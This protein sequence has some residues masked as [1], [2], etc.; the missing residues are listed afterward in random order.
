[1]EDKVVRL[2]GLKGVR[3][4]FNMYLGGKD[5]DALFTA[6]RELLDN[7]SDLALK[8]NLKVKV[9]LAID[10]GNY[11]VVDDGPGMPV[12]KDI[13]EDER[14]RKEKL[15]SLYV[16]TGLT[17]AGT[18]FNSDKTSKGTHGIGSKSTNAISHVYEVWTFKDGSWWYIQY[19]NAVLT[20]EP[21][22][23]KAPPVVPFIGKVKKGTIVHCKPDLSLFAKDTKFP[24]SR[25]K[26]WCELSSYLIPNQTSAVYTSK[27]SKVYEPQGPEVYIKK[28]CERLDVEVIGKAL[29]CHDA[30]F[31]LAVAWSK[32][33]GNNVKAYTNGLYNS[34]G[35]EH[36]R[37]M[38]SALYKSLEPYKGKLKF[39]PTHLYEGMIG[40]VNCHIPAADYNT[41]TKDKLTDERAYGI[42][43]PGMLEAFENFWKANKTLAKAVCQKA[44]N[45]FEMMEEI[46]LS[47]QALGDLKTTSK[48]RTYLP[49]KLA[50]CKTKNPKE[51]ELYIV[52]GESAKG[53]CTEARDKYYQEV[54]PMK[55][56]PINPYKHKPDRVLA[57]DEVLNILKSVGYDPSKKDPY[58]SLRVGRIIILPDADTDGS[59]IKLL[60][61]AVIFKFLKPMV[62]EGKV[63]IS[64]APLFSAKVGKETYYG[65]SVE[66]VRSKIPTKKDVP[67]SRLKGLGETSV[68]V[69]RS[70][71][72]NPASRKLKRLVPPSNENLM[73]YIS[74]LDENVGARQ[75]L[76]GLG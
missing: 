16:I 72:F 43:Y 54:L 68:E 55:G 21:K 57:N 3:Q 17:H 76:L 23:V 32:A 59:H 18:N 67:I 40:L 31:D 26:H 9:Q 36:I 2:A 29:V 14:G 27:G 35:G 38:R 52:E 45:I 56:K 44:A 60:A 12:K 39:N 66:D 50:V 6:V 73:K 75:E 69:L 28:E 1:M 15:S 58:S 10:N 25:L 64:D 5:S 48:G 30:G 19:K 70:A 53:P 4:K 62:D 8:Y 42:C 49:D 20:V 74:M 37:A 34:E 51:R 63:Y 71:S 47:K 13:F 33:D 65:E 41:Q 46:K 7:V 11:W 61:S 24:M 22:K